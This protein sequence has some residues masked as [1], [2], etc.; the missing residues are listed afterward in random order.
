MAPEP[1]KQAEIPDDESIVDPVWLTAALGRP[2]RNARI[3]PSDDLTGG[4]ISTIRRLEVVPKP[5]PEDSH[6]GDPGGSKTYVV[7]IRRGSPS[8]PQKG[9]AR[10]AHFYNE[11]A[12]DLGDAVA[13]CQ[14]AAGD[15]GTGSKVLILDDLSAAATGDNGGAGGGGGGARKSGELLGTAH[16]YTW[17][18][19][20]EVLAMT[21]S[22]PGPEAVISTTF[23]AL[24]EVHAKFWGRER[25]REVRWLAGQMEAE[26]DEQFWLSPRLWK[27]QRGG[28]DGLNMTP[29]LVAVMDAAMA[30]VSTNFSRGRQER[31]EFTLCHGDFHP[32]NVMWV[33]DQAVLYDW[34][35]VRLGLPGQELGQYMMNVSVDLRR[36]FER[37]AL[38]GYHRRLGELGVSPCRYSFDELWDDYVFGGSAKFIWMLPI[39]I[40]FCP[41]PLAQ[42][43]CD[44]MASFFEDHGVT[45]QNAPLPRK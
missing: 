32:F 35:M 1:T 25:L 33:N 5:Y 20:E 24:A 16:P 44:Q 23:A 17:G 37:E 41:M 45:E 9:L 27:S 36:K 11:L 28:V 3:V 6:N 4:Q 26:N 34:E 15:L 14:Y 13:G 43:C 8:D 21:E 38:S 40:A 12:P 42:F 22:G 19:E 10:E 29:D 30:K 39:L 18:K 7:K 2:I 31:K